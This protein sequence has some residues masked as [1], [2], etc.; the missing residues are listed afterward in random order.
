MNPVSV[1]RCLSLILRSTKLVMDMDASE[2]KDPFVKLDLTSSLRGKSAIA[3]VNLAY[4]QC[5]SEGPRQSASGCSNDVVDR[6]GM[7][8][9][10]IGWYFIVLGHF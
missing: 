1:L 8:R 9:K 5:A 7:G 4:F 10:R 6:G 2:H 3:S